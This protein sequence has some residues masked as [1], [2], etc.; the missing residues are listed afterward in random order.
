MGQSPA[1]VKAGNHVLLRAVMVGTAHAASSGRLSAPRQVRIRRRAGIP[2]CRSTEHSCS[3]LAG[4]A[5]SSLS[6]G[7]AEQECSANWQTGMSAL[8]TPKS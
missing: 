6:R 5:E 3:V 7:F 4:P 1:R 2:A 8:H